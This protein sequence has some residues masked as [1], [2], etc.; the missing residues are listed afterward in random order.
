MIQDMSGDKAL[1]ARIDSVIS[2]ALTRLAEE[3]FM[4]TPLTLESVRV[5]MHRRR[6]PRVARG[7]VRRPALM[8][9]RRP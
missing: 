4:E 8:T 5:A 3:A 7:R 1:L 2:Q 9:R 6:Q